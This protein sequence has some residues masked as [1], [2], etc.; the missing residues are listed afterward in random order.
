MTIDIEEMSE[1]YNKLLL[2]NKELKAREHD[3]TN[4]HALLV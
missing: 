4:K 3:I 2:V 1:E